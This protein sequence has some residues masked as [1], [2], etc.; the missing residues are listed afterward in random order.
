MRCAW[1]GHSLDRKQ[2]T[3][4]EVLRLDLIPLRRDVV[5]EMRIVSQNGPA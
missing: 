3:F 1:N 4:A 2:T 5:F